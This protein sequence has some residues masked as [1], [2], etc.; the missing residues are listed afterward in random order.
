MK[1]GI[2]GAGISGLSAGYELA[3]E[4]HS[5]VIFEKSQVPGGLG[6]YIKIKGNYIER[7]YHHFFETDKYII[8]YA[9][10]LEISDKLH[11]YSAKTGIFT[12][13]KIFPFSSITNLL[14]FLPLSFIDRLRCG[15]VLAFLKIL[16]KP[17]SS[18]DH[19]SAEK[20]LKKYAGNNV[21]NVIWKPL[22]EGKFSKYANWVPMMWLWGRVRDRSLKL[23]YFDGSVKTLFDSLIT[24]IK[25]YNGDIILGAEISG[26]KQKAN[27]VII[28]EKNKTYT[29][30]KVIIATVSP[31]V[32]ILLKDTLPTSYRNRLQSIDHLGAICVIVELKFS[33]QSQYWLNICTPHAPVLV[34]VE[35]TNM[36]NSSSYGKRSIVYLANYIHRDDKRF[37]L[38]DKEIVKEYTSILKKINPKF[39]DSWIIK[40]YV[41]RV[42]R[43][44]TIFQLDALKNKPSIQT[45]LKNIYM[46]NIDQMYPHDRN[47]N[48]GIELGKKVAKM[49]SSHKTQ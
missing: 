48:Q 9:K 29:F 13:N 4:K 6:T 49:I 8:E 37:T 41:S 27:K 35:H 43:A 25:K 47:L 46:I 15:L 11:F 1:I 23:G 3:K 44:Q 28:F 16:S 31:I 10:E 21:Y 19:I 24:Q 34:M 2:I 45:P 36:I 26:I 7:F 20:W 38:S 39:S 18:F 5:V 30:D 22:L 12:N 40:T 33:I 14:L 32:N 42:P 17:F